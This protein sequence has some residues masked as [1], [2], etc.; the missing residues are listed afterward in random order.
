[1]TNLAL[2]CIFGEKSAWGKKSAWEP[3]SQVPAYYAG[4]ALEFLLEPNFFLPP[5]IS[6]G[7][8]L[9][10]PKVVPSKMDLSGFSRL[11]RCVSS[12]HLYF[13]L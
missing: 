2:F 8:A 10:G 1:M 9:E 3:G 12:P 6:F 4:L 13:N 11:G 5:L 7:S